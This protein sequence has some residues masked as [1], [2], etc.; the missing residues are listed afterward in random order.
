MEVYLS[1][2]HSAV[3]P[4]VRLV[5]SRKLRIKY[6]IRYVIAMLSVNDIP[7][8]SATYDMVPEEDVSDWAKELLMSVVL[9]QVL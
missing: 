4:I 8:R 7:L 2:R 6:R 9:A 3:M 1:L 5:R